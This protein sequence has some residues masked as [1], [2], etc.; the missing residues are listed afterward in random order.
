MYHVCYF[1]R[2]IQAGQ[3]YPTWMVGIW[4]LVY[5]PPRGKYILYQRGIH[6]PPFLV[7]TPEKAKKRAADM[8]F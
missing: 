8:K 4:I 3:A 2:I 1:R 6:K 5:I 7:G